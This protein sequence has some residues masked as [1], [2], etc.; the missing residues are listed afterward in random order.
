MRPFRDH[1]GILVPLPAANV[2]TD[3]IIP[4]RFIHR[5]RKAGYGDQLFHD[6]RYGASGEE[7][8]AF[9]LN[10]APYGTGSILV[11]G[12]NFGCGSSREQAVWALLDHGFRAV[13][14][15]SFGDI[16]FNNALNNGLLTIVA[17]AALHATLVTWS[18]TRPGVAAEIDLVERTIRLDDGQRLVFEIDD[19]RREALLAGA[20]EIEMTLTALD[21]INAFETGYFDD[22]PWALLHPNPDA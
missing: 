18:T 13:I 12:P 9:I 2:D 5:P 20:S 4:A 1:R 11:G 14:A 22:N 7:R 16:F 6:L 8:G 19:Y 3:Q 17:N 10:Q 15:P 21:R